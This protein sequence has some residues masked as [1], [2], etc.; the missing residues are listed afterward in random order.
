MRGVVQGVGFRPFVHNLA[1]ELGLT[2]WVSNSAAGVELAIQGPP[3]A[4][5]E[6]LRKLATQPPPLAHILEVEREE[7]PLRPQESGFA[8][9]PSKAG[10]RRTLI[11]P[12]S[13]TC[14]ACLAELND[15]SD[16]RYRYPF[17]NCTHCG[18]RY[19]I[20]KD[21][22]YDRPLTTMA[23]FIMCPACLA[24]YENPAD[25]RFHAQ[26]NACPECGP[27]LWLTDA[28]GRE[29]ACAD[30][31][32]EAAKALAAGQVLAL[33]GLGGFHL[34]VDAL[35]EQAVRTLRD[36]KHREEKPLALMAPDL[37]TAQRLVHLDPASQAALTSRQRPIVLCPMRSP[38]P[39]APAVNPRNRWL[40]IMLPYT[41]LHHLLLQEGFTALVMTSGNLSEEP[42]CLDNQEALRRL[43]ASA[44]GGGIADRFLLHDRDIYLRSDDSV[45]RVSG[46]SLRQMRRSRGFVPVPILLAPGLVDEDHPPI[47]AVGAHLKNTLCLLRGREAF[48]SQHVGDL[49]NLE[50]LEFFELTAGHLARILEAEPAI[51]AC[52]QHPDYLSTRWAREQGLPLVRVQHHHA[53]AVAVMAEHGLTGQV[54]ALSLDGTGL[55]PDGAIWGGELLAAW[56]GSYER[57]GHLRRFHLP[58]G[59]GAVKNPWRI[60]MALL[61]ELYGDRGAEFCARLLAPQAQHWPLMTR[62]IQRGLNAPLTSSLGRLFDGVA[63][64][65]GLRGE[66][67]YEG[68]AAVE[69]EQV[70]DQ[71][72]PGAY[73]FALSRQDSML[74]LDWGPAL[75]ALVRE[76]EAG[77]GPEPVAAR[78]HRGLAQGLAAWVAAVASERG[79]DRVVLGGGCFMNATLL[80]TLPPLL[81]A[82]GLRVYSPAAAPAG[83]GGLCLG[84]ALAAAQAWRAGRVGP[85]ELELS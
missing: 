36:R 30:P 27:R 64:L 53:H 55:G 72:E 71:E 65:C 41:P 82:S 81:E 45:V 33:K 70:Q 80:E 47:L 29:L 63:A 23:V 48:V 39:V 10:I 5:D 37:E 24:E 17:I 6:F 13:A 35:N 85:G 22:P 43:G 51:L 54:L 68:Q 14:P 46:G 40:G 50:T 57:M 11:S 44:P 34:A 61:W 12:D 1:Q 15:P 8:I 49:E 59:E 20:I 73:P 25:R 77:S 4:L 19:T 9:R 60:A 31:V 18:P 56:A 78:F 75:A 84:Q 16:R 21:L 7:R 76:V 66:V 52:D 83:D 26:P 32:R 62:L 58:S 28:Q 3:S 74:I 38:S 42:I 2:G 69:L 79:L 67:A